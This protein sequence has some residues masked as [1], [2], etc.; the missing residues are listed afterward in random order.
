MTIWTTGLSVAI[1]ALACARTIPAEPA[2]ASKVSISQAAIDSDLLEVSI[3][4]LEDF[5]RDHKYTVTQVV[6]WYLDRIRRYNGVYGALEK[7][8]EAGA[9]ATAEQ[10][11]AEARAGGAGLA[12]GPLWG[13]PI[14]IKENTSVRG[15]IT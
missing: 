1:L 4:Q 9:L 3:P 10:E 6:H 15:L 12:R 11:D 13:V 2:T 7:V 8:D 14:V 5:Y